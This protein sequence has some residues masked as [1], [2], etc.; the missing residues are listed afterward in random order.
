MELKNTIAAVAMLVMLS[1]CA[2]TPSEPKSLPDLLGSIRAADMQYQQGKLDEAERLYL[3]VLKIDPR[4]VDA[5]LRLGVIAH[6][7][8]DY[9]AAEAKFKEVLQRDPRHLAAL[10][11]LAA[12]ELEQAHQH[13]D[14]YLRL[15]PPKADQR[16]QVR[17]VVTAIE[18]FAKS[19]E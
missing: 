11:N 10:Y 4:F 5:H 15:S 18:S 16:Q 1:G 19:K 13:L 7:R 3:E 14:L 2:S 8:G 12:I 6:Q 9:V 17:D